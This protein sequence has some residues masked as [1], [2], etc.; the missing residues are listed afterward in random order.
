ME[1]F[2]TDIFQ[3]GSMRFDDVNYDLYNQFILIDPF[4]NSDDEEAVKSLKGFVPAKVSVDGK[5]LEQGLKKSD[6]EIES[7]S[8]L[9]TKNIKNQQIENYDHKIVDTRTQQ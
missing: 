2:K 1:R 5:S 8:K 7:E 9:T 3:R 4:Y 6:G